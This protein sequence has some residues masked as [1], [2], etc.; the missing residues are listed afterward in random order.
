M[1]RRTQC[2][3]V[4]RQS[5]INQNAEGIDVVHDDVNAD[6]AEVDVGDDAQRRCIHDEL[7]D[8][9]IERLEKLGIH[10]ERPAASGKA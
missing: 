4:G 1:Y 9:E 6:D 7:V 2:D 3:S 10:D 5:T 8:H